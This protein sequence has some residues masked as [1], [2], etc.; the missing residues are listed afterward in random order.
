MIVLPSNSTMTSPAIANASSDGLSLNDKFDASVEIHSADNYETYRSN[1][2]AEFSEEDD[3]RI[4][5][6]VDIRFLPLLGFAYVLKQID[7]SNAAN[8]KVLQV[9]ES[10]NILKE[11]HMTANEYNWVATI[12]FVSLHQ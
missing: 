12:Y 7:Y 4:R 2:L 8:I 6:K 5:R 9:G 1:F 11:L 3:R 10:R